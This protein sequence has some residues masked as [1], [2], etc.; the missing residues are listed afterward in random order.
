MNEKDHA[1]DN[2]NASNPS[3]MPGIRKTGDAEF[4][5]DVTSCHNLGMETEGLNPYATPGQ[6]EVTTIGGARGATNFIKHF[7]LASL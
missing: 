2:Q 3:P 6:V 5:I 7:A 1:V 4:T